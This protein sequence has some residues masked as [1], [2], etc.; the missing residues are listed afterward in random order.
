VTDERYLVLRYLLQTV[1]RRQATTQHLLEAAMREI[2]ALNAK[3]DALKDKLEAD[4]TTD[5]QLVADR[6]AKIAELRGQL[7]SLLATGATA[8]EIKAIEDRID[9][10]AAEITPAGQPLPAGEP[11]APA[12]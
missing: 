5:A 3:L 8:E 9:A 11:P 12:P 2:D 7:D 6:D 1:L 4:Q 10:L